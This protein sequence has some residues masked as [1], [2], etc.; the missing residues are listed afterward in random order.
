MPETPMTRLRLVEV[1]LERFKAAFRPSQP[2]EFRPF[3]ILIG[4]NGSGK[5]TVLEALQWIDTALR[6][7]VRQAC[8]PYNGVH[9]LVGHLSCT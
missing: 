6:Q 5:S 9:D 8:D 4:R 2:I 3:N 1:N 7:D